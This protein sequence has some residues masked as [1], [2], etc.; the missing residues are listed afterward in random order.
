MGGC[1]DFF[2]VIRFNHMDNI[3]LNKFYNLVSDNQTEY[4]DDFSE[5]V[6]LIVKTKEEGKIGDADADVLLKLVVSKEIKGQLNQLSRWAQ[7]LHADEKKENYSLLFNLTSKE[8]K[9]A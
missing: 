9:Y 4:S 3:K 1:V 5:M 8:K 2:T 7:L 6:D